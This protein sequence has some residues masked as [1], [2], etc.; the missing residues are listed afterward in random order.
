MIEIIENCATLVTI[1]YGTIGM[2]CIMFFV[3][4][5]FL[6]DAVYQLIKWLWL[7]H[8]YENDITPDKWQALVKEY[9]R[10]KNI[11]NK[12]F[13]VIIQQVKEDKEKKP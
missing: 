12:Y 10:L 8:K 6:S 2:I 11:E 1:N 4:G 3:F 9:R 7:K 13:D 5:V